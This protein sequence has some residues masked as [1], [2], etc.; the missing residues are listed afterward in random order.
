MNTQLLEEARQLTIDDQIDLVAAL[1]DEIVKDD[2]V[3]LPTDAQKIELDRRLAE[4]LKDPNDVIPW[5]EVKASAMKH[6]GR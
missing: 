6:I 5:A 1:W 4:H 2:A 3:L